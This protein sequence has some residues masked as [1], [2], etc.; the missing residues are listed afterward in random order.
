MDV[1][2]YKGDCLKEMDNIPNK[3]INLVLCDLPYGKTKNS[4]DTPIDLEGLWK[5]YKRVCADDA[6]ILLFAQGSFYI[7]L[8]C[9]NRKMFRYDL[10]WD[11]M[12][13]TGFLNA[14]R[15]PLR[16]HEQIAVF[17][18]KMPKYNPQFHKGKPL[19]GRNENNVFENRQSTYGNFKIL[20]AKRGNTD[21]YPLSVIKIP[22]Y[23]PSDCMHPTEKPIELLKYLILSYSDEGDTVLDNCM[24]CGSAGLASVIT[25]R[26]FIGIE[27]DEGFYDKA[28]KRILS[29]KKV[30]DGRKKMLKLRAEGKIV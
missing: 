19:H 17:Y 1:K 8:V 11:K 14:N 7:D 27:L 13:S 22:K 5:Q 10:V 6:A 4:W 2:L 15:M 30:S 3:S 21:K 9:S 12:M 16:N 18:K 28:E 20:P 29:A 24:G 23:H 25:E 26:N